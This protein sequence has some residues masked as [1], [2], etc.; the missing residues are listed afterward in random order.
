[1]IQ[2][3]GRE[4]K[5]IYLLAARLKTLFTTPPVAPP[6]APM[7]SDPITSS[8]C[9]VNE[10]ERSRPCDNRLVTF[11][12]IESYHVRP[13]GDHLFVIVVYCGNGRNDWAAVW[14]VGKP[15]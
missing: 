4:N 13:S 2:T 3:I 11:T 8:F 9:Q 12:C 7:R 1:M 5:E 6:E 15:A 10:L 14:A